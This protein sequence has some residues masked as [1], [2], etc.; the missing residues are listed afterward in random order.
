MENLRIAEIDRRIEDLKK[1]NPEIY[2]WISLKLKREFLLDELS[3]EDPARNNS[4]N[5]AE[6]KETECCMINMRKKYD[7][8]KVY[9]ACLSEKEMLK[10][11]ESR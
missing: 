1:T 3:S 11:K 9:E 2:G 6:L 4:E 10:K 5:K 7:S 8:I